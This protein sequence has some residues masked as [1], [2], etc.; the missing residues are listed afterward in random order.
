MFG[1]LLVLAFEGQAQPRCGGHIDRRGQKEGGG[2]RL[3][4]SACDSPSSFTLHLL[5]TANLQG[6][7]HGPVGL[8][9][10]GAGI[11]KLQLRSWL[12]PDT[13][14]SARIC[15]DRKSVV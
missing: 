13:I 6:P 4:S 15:V 11:G 2:L 8:L 9:E 14:N 1:P 10:G 7:G 3:A 12:I 5:V